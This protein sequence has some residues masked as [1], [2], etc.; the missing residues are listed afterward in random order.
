[1]PHLQGNG[2]IYTDLATMAGVVTR[3]EECEGRRFRPEV[4][5]YKLGGRD[6]SEVL[7]MSVDQ[8][9]PFFAGDVEDA[10]DAKTPR[11]TRSCTDSPTSDLAICA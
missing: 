11:R 2:V 3:C 1:M 7:A 4:L 5:D 6:I 8:A 9:L 10:A